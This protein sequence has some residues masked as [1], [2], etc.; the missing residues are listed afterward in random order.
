MIYVGGQKIENAT[1]LS[2]RCRNVLSMIYGGPGWLNWAI[3]DT[4]IPVVQVDDEDNLLMLVQR[5]LHADDWIRF[6]TF[7][8]DI[9]K[10]LSFSEI[11]F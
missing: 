1:V 8:A 11:S 9:S 7:R 5:G 6:N 3:Q 4:N 10:V 2:V